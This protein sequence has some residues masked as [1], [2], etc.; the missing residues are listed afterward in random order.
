MEC[1]F[2]QIHLLQQRA[3]IGSTMKRYIGDLLEVNL[4][5]LPS[6]SSW[7]FAGYINHLSFNITSCPPFQIWRT[8][9][10]LME[11]KAATTLI[12]PLFN[13]PLSQCSN[14]VSKIVWP[15]SL[16]RFFFGFRSGYIFNIYSRVGHDKRFGKICEGKRKVEKRNKVG[17]EKP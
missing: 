1:C 7:H 14:I 8:V 6:N 11:N 9:L 3:N 5:S 10:I 17:K 15:P 4:N 13:F 16:V 12:T 2:F